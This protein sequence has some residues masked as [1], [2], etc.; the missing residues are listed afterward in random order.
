MKLVK[1]TKGKVAMVDDADYDWLSKWK[2]TYDGRYA[3][4]KEWP[5]KRKIYLHRL[6]L[7]EP[8]GLEV[9]HKDLDKLN[10]QRNNLRI[11]RRSNNGSNKLKQSNNTSGYK[12]ITCRKQANGMKWIAQIQYNGKNHYIGIF[13]DS[14]NAAKAYNEKADELFGEFARLND[15]TD[16]EAIVMRGVSPNE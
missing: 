5:S 6:L 1:L 11:G 13:D 7:G 2:W 12:G 3:H 16:V 9:D 15:V 14:K 8:I 10:C 4:R